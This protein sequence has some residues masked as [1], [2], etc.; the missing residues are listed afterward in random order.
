[1][2]SEVELVV[3]QLTTIVRVLEEHDF[4]NIAEVPGEDRSGEIHGVLMP[5]WSVL[6]RLTGSSTRFHQST[7]PLMKS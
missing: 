5:T 1:M 7:N 2:G 4:Q 6:P 3:S